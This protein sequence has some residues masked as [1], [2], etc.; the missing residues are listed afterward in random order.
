MGNAFAKL[1]CGRTTLAKARTQVALNK[2]EGVVKARL[3]LAVVFSNAS[4]SELV[5]NRSSGHLTVNHFS[6]DS[7]P[8]PSIRPFPSA[9]ILL[10]ESRFS[11]GRERPIKPLVYPPWRTTNDT[12]TQPRCNRSAVIYR[13]GIIRSR[14]LR[15][16]EMHLN[17]WLIRP[18]SPS[19]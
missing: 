8:Q 16:L 11:S 13:S 2:N 10:S 18:S 3:R 19:R 4:T 9:M 7:F 14:S 17:D 12:R 5:E 1:D 6:V 15:F